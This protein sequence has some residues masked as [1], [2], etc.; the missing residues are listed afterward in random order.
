MPASSSLAHL[1]CDLPVPICSCF[2]MPAAISI[3]SGA[4]NAQANATAS[5]QPTLQHLSWLRTWHLCDSKS[6]L[7]PARQWPL[8]AQSIHF[9]SLQLQS[10]SPPVQLACLHVMVLL[11]ILHSGARLPEV[12]PLRP[13]TCSCPGPGLHQPSDC[14]DGC[15]LCHR[16][17]RCNRSCSGA[18]FCGCKCEK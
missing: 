2:S 9:T 6:V 10:P 16:Q 15:G 4:A 5:E 18:G 1:Q 13:A 17:G 11:M 7:I 14:G 12:A 3:G 8:C